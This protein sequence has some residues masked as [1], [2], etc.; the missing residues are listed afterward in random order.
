MNLSQV[1]VVIPAHNRP[2]RLRRLLYYYSE[3]NINVIVSDS[4]KCVFP[5]LA[6]FPNIVYEHYANETFIIK[7]NKILDRIITPYVFFCADDDFIVPEAISEIVDF[8]DENRDYCSAQG[9]YLT[10]KE[11]KRGLQFS[12]RYIRFFDKDI[13]GD[14][15]VD[16]L[17]QYKNAYAS[18]LYSIIRTDVFKRMYL[19]CMENDLP[20]FQNLYLAEWYF[21]IYSLMH[22]KHKTLPYFYSAREEIEASAATTTIPFEVVKASD[23]YKKEY[24]GF[25][26]ILSKE[27]SSIMHI[28]HE[29]ATKYV[30]QM[31]E[32]PKRSF[33]IRVKAHII[34]CLGRAKVLDVLF[35][36][37]YIQKGLKIVKNMHSYPCSFTT[38]EKE[39]IISCIKKYQ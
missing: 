36:K 17:M 18:N 9:H 27:L 32:M 16:R 13:N 8:M 3:T 14:N 11:T 31:I 35:E 38:P 6:E 15:P 28:P 5:F 22:G 29:E 33:S 19:A 2:E 21:I 10:F 4:S 20:I 12:P 1:T 26:A 30:L 25:L 34:K 37:R 39:R 24:N 7:I 23:A